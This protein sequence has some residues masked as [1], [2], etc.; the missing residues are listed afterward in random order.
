MFLGYVTSMASRARGNS[1]VESNAERVE[2]SSNS[3]CLS[4]SPRTNPRQVPSNLETSS[5]V[6]IH[7]LNMRLVQALALAKSSRFGA[8]LMLTTG[9]SRSCMLISDIIQSS[10][11]AEHVDRSGQ[12][13]WRSKRIGR[14]AL[15][16][17]HQPEPNQNDGWLWTSDSKLAI[18]S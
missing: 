17:G 7:L 15:E 18:A 11:L 13:A 3:L 2:Q 4:D 16:S 12:C 6:R 10:Y 8:L 5:N 14:S 1:L 9:C